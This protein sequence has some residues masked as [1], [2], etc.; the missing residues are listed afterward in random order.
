MSTGTTT[1]TWLGHAT[2][3]FETADGKRLLLD[4]WL[5]DNPAF[6]AEWRERLTS[7]IDGILVSHGHFDHTRDVV[8]LAQANGCSVATQM[9]LGQWLVGKG[10]AEDKVIGFNRGGCIELAGVRV[11]LT[12]ARHSSSADDNGRSVYLGESCGF[13]LQFSAGFTVYYTG[14]TCI[15]S[16]M[17]LMGQLYQ[18]D[19]VI[20]P[21]GDFFTM[22]PFQAAH[23]LRLIGAPKAIPEHYGTF[24]ILHGT[25]EQLRT[26]LAKL[27]QPTEVVD[28]KPGESWT[29]AQ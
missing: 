1:I 6:P 18:P 4:P 10:L 3:L 8:E 17:Q 27:S 20:L 16:G 11:T 22:G 9:E 24:P 19:L 26:E 21:I 7:G 15:F 5:T 2:F 13:I 23:S 25:P 14:D 29:A 12:D 28:L